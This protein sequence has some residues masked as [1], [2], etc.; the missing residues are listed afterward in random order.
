VR[1]QETLSR[2]DQPPIRLVA[3]VGDT[4][5]GLGIA[6]ISIFSPE[7]K[8]FVSVIVLPE[9]RR[10]GIASRLYTPLVD[11]ARKRNASGLRAGVHESFL[12]VVQ[13]WLEREG[14]AEIERMRPSELRI[15]EMDFEQWRAAETRVETSGITLTSLAE[16]DSDE[17]RRKLWQLSELTRRD[18]P[19]HGPYEEFP[20]EQFTG[21][22]DRPEALPDC[23]VIA[24]DGDRFVGSTTLIHQT[25]DRAL[26]GLT[27]VDPEYRG[28]GVALAIKVRCAE[29]ARKRGY[30]K[31]HTFNHVN[32]PAMLAVNDRLGYVALP[33]AI[34]FEKN[35]QAD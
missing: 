6:G 10:Q 21:L 31:M 20:F 24:R 11:S 1:V 22:L 23:L 30:R 8:Y 27:G 2:P 19:H 12:P 7:G 4:P 35:V 33:Q 29:L 16:I 17:T 26:T 5:V 9:Y 15:D 3:R 28:R 13:P 32:N 25:P 14:Y 34:L 18:I